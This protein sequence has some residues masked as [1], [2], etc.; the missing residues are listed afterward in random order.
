MAAPASS[1]RW[2]S[3]PALKGGRLAGANVRRVASIPPIVHIELILQTYQGI[4]ICPYHYSVI[5]RSLAS[6]H[7]GSEGAAR[8]VL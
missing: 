5:R 3:L 6:G 4:G 8:L 7:P 1:G 2:L